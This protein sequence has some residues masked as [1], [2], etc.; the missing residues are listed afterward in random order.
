MSRG[1]HVADLFAQAQ[2]RHGAA[3]DAFL[4]ELRKEDGQL[5][6]ELGSLLAASAGEVG[7]LDESPWHDSPH[8]PAVLFGTPRRVIRIR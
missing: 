1:E 2:A 4:A 5:A 7:L 8:E 3:R 6:D